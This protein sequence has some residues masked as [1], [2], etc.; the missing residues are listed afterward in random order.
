L[1]ALPF[2]MNYGMTIYNKDIFDKFGI[3]YPKDM[4]TWNEMLDL[5]KKLTKLEQGV[6]YVGIDPG[7]I[8]QLKEQ[9]SL[10]YVN[11]RQDMLC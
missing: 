8:D 5:G 10:P 7:P 6:Q 3:P 1:Y 4:M 2:S 9:Y 11:E